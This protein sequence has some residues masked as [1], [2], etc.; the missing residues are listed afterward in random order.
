MVF[1]QEWAV[2]ITSNALIS[3]GIMKLKFKLW[4]I[5]YSLNTLCDLSK[6]VGE[7]VHW[8]PVLSKQGWNGL[9]RVDSAL[10]RRSYFFR[11]MQKS[12]F[13][14][15]YLTSICAKN[16]LTSEEIYKNTIHTTPGNSQ[17]PWISNII[18]QNHLSCFFHCFFTLPSISMCSRMWVSPVLC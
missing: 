7:R 9:K 14:A 6:R 8:S 17:F 16:P 18:Y 13:K 4:N 12:Y 1:I 2:A 3:Q 10:W 5:L 15:K 11:N